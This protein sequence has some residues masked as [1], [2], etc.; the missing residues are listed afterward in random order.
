MHAD[1]VSSML[2]DACSIGGERR[3]RLKGRFKRQPRPYKPTCTIT[4]LRLP[5]HCALRS[6]CQA[7][8]SPCYC[9]TR[10]S[11]CAYRQGVSEIYSA[12]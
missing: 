8:L 5:S 11:V 4:W 1:C 6:S 10:L 2:L 9:S 3:M 12:G 7:C